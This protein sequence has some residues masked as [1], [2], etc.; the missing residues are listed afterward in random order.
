MQKIILLLYNFNFL[1]GMGYSSLLIV[2]FAFPYQTV[3]SYPAG[4]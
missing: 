2:H 1:Y 3:T 4:P